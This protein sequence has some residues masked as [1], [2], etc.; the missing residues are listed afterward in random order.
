MKKKFDLTT[1]ELKFQLK[2]AGVK[3]QPT[4][5]HADYQFTSFTA[6]YPVM[7]MLSELTEAGEVSRSAF[8][9]AL[10]S[11]AHERWKKTGNPF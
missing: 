4:Y 3:V 7:N 9:Q 8:I 1:A 5:K 6:P 10:I 2:A 11:T